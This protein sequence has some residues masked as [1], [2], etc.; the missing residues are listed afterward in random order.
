MNRRK[1]MVFFAPLAIVGIAAFIAL[2]GYA[3]MWLWNWL[4]PGLFGWPVLTFWKA[5]ALLALCRILFGSFGGHRGGPSM[6]KRRLQERMEE[7]MEWMSPEEKDR[8]RERMREKLGFGPDAPE[9][10]AK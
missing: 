2:G 10:E 7:R 5:V 4:L 6:S 1:K 3:V 8:F 9:A